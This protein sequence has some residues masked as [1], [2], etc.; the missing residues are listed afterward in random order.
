MGLPLRVDP[1][2]LRTLTLELHQLAAEAARMAAE[3]N[4]DLA[5]EAGCG[6]EEHP[7]FRACRSVR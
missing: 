7:R 3:L 2:E 5:H 1:D 6:G 4:A